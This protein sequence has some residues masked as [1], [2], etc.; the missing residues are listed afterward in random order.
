VNFASILA[1]F[2]ND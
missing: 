1:H 2:C